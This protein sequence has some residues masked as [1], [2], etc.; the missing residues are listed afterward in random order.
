MEPSPESNSKFD[1]EDNFIYRYNLKP[2]EMYSKE[3]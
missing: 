2:A 1:N 3:R